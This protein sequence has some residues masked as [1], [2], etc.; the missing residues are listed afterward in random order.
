MAYRPFVR[1]YMCIYFR[2]YNL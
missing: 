2:T 1:G